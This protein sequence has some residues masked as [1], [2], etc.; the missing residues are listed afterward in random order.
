MAQPFSR[1][2]AIALLSA[3]VA[4]VVGAAGFLSASVAPTHAGCH[5]RTSSQPQ[6]ADYRCCVGRHASAL[7]TGVFSLRPA[8]HSVE[9]DATEVVLAAS[10]SKAFPALVA[11][12]GGLPG[13]LILRI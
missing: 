13:I 3:M 1:M 12:S 4:V 9:A 11:P 2:I 5:S 10:D 7:T 8:V 6:P